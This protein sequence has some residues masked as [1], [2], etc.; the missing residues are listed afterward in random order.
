[1]KKLLWETQFFAIS[2]MTGEIETYRGMFIQSETLQNATKGMR[3]LGLDY[4]Q[5]TGVS[6]NSYDEIDKE[7]TLYKA[8]IDP[9]NIVKGMTFDDFME[10]L[11]IATTED[12]LLAAKEAFI[13]A[14]GLDEYVK[15]IDIHIKLKY[16]DKKKTK[17]E[18]D[19]EETGSQV[20]ED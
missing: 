1:M 7:E 17:D 2:A 15:V 14:K 4:L 5:L 8:L 6:Y 10:W 9:H 20:E 3:A 19:Q 12:D 11:E 13:E 18:D 16:G